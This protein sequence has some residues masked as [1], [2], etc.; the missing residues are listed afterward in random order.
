MAQAYLQQYERFENKSI[1]LDSVSYYLNNIDVNTN[2]GMYISIYYL[3]LKE[4]YSS[5]MEQIT[6]LNVD[7]L[8]NYS[9]VHTD[10]SNQ[11]AWTCYRIGEACTKE[12][13]LKLAFKF[14][15]QA[16]RLA[17]YNLEFRNKYGVALFYDNKIDFAIDEF[18]FILNE[19]NNFVSA[20]NNL[21]YLH[22][23]LG[24]K[25]KALLNYNYALKLNPNHKKTL[26]NKS[27]LLL[28]YEDSVKALLDVKKLLQLYPEDQEVINLL[29]KFNESS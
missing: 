26:I 7:S 5:I 29:N 1:Y 28:F 4:D 2:L 8:L 3:F 13:D 18:N 21:G 23:N 9:L 16:V 22:F 15:Q 25:D 6:S 10:Y 14:Y 11:D 17:P 27:S 12:G 20:Y 19:D 24:E